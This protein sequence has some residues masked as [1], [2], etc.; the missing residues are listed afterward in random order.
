MSAN[1]CINHEPKTSHSTAQ[2]TVQVPPNTKSCRKRKSY[3]SDHKDSHSPP[4][5]RPKISAENRDTTDS[6]DEHELET[7]LQHHKDRLHEL[8]VQHHQSSTELLEAKQ[9]NIQQKNDIYCEQILAGNHTSNEQVMQM[10]KTHQKK[11]DEIDK[12][13][14]KKI[15]K[16]LKQHTTDRTQL[17]TELCKQICHTNGD[18]KVETISES[19]VTKATK[20][21]KKSKKKT[22]KNKDV[23][24]KKK[25]TKA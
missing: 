12:K 1:A 15:C 3:E 23:R 9:K 22:K 6:K 21:R 17:H 20:P 11:L 4:L 13:Y 5:K 25:N 10:T 24:K 19:S 7:L 16:L 8:E 2:A 14:K 18:I